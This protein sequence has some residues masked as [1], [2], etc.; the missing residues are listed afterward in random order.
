M[1]LHYTWH[2]RTLPSASS[3]LL[4]AY[5]SGRLE[6]THLVHVLR[7]CAGDCATALSCCAG[8]LRILVPRLVVQL[9]RALAYLHDEQQV[10]HSD[11]KPSNVLLDHDGNL[12]LCDLGSAARCQDGRS[13]LVGSPAYQAPEVVAITTLGLNTTGASFSYPSDVWQCGVVLHELLS[14]ELPF[15]AEP[16]DPAAQPSAILFRQPAMPEGAFSP[17]A[18]SLVLAMLSKQAYLRPAAAC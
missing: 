7:S 2:A 4:G 8:A 11:L 17:A 9:L 15:P 12:Q 6:T 5:P 18:R 1:R 10:V 3:S 13:T 16:Q 14:G